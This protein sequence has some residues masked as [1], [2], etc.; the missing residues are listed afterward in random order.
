MISF[1]KEFLMIRK[2]LYIFLKFPPN[3]NYFKINYRHYYCT[4]KSKNY[5]RPII[6]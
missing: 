2:M 1:E 5:D 4:C 3:N 6:F